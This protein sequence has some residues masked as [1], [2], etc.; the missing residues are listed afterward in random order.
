MNQTLHMEH[1]DDGHVRLSFELEGRAVFGTGERFDAV[2]R[3]GLKTGF[4]TLDH[5]TTQGETTY[6]PI[7]FLLTDAG[8]G[9]HI[10]STL[11]MQVSVTADAKS[12]LCTVVADVDVGPGGAAP[13]VRFYEGTPSEVLSAFV[14]DT[15]APVLPPKW[16]LGV[17]ISANRWNTQHEVEN[18]VLRAEQEG[19]PASVVVIEAWSDEST[20]HEWNPGVWPDP[21]GMTDRIHEAG[22]RLVLWQIPVLKHL[23]TEH[24]DP[25]CEE[26]NLFAAEHGFAVQAA[27]GTPFRI[28]QDRWFS[29][30]MLLDFTNPTAVDWWFDKRRH[31]LDLGVDGFKTDGGEMVYDPDARFFDGRRGG[32]MRNAYPALYTKRYADFIGPDR[33]LFS[34]AGSTGAQTSPIHWAGDQLSTYDEFRSALR[35][36]LS[37]GLS[38]VL[39]WTFDVAGF[40]GP[41]PTADLYRRGTQAAVYTSALQW[42]SDMPRGQYGA[43]L[44]DADKTNDR[45]P[46]NMAAVTGD[47]GLLT[48]T[49][50]QAHW[51]MNL[52][53]HAYNEA[54]RSVE[55]GLPLMRHLVLDFPE[56]R[57]C[58]AIDDQFL[59]GSLLV[60]PVLEENV[61]ERTV[62]L[63][64]G[65]WLDLWSGE[66]REGGHRF[67]SH[68]GSDRI[69]VYL[70]E[71]T[72]LPLN[73]DATFRFGSDVGNR[74]DAYDR[75]TFLLAGNRGSHA[76]RDDLGN[77]FTLVWADGRISVSP[78]SAGRVPKSLYFLSVRPI[79]GDR[80]SRLPDPP[81]EPYKACRL[82]VG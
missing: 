57:E 41:L 46:W 55:S 80:V 64:Q 82:D 10:M 43:T 28:P 8:Q 35:A 45:S 78:A 16:S 58:H 12:G 79:S 81:M 3:T 61:R 13:M 24:P 75:L 25:R 42:H 77:A 69:P 56:D 23:D 32:E 68:C 20:F 34:R 21:A 1:I 51:R 33:I 47:P 5:F 70:R 54:I 52:M 44:S 7:P 53:P 26:E 72:A 18:Q 73:L 37:A 4:Q 22:M 31:L 17:W 11:P 71:G 36:G 19:Y 60:A 39:F 27:D 67:V 65:T 29:R 63:P 2:D 38:G 40:T 76:F 9:A 49:V 74:M 14:H 6:L 48:H 15:G 66:E 50:Q 62:Y 30:S 59:F